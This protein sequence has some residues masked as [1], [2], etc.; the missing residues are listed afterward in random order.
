M[1]TYYFSSRP[2]KIPAVRQLIGWRV[3]VHNESIQGTL[4]RRMK[5]CCWAFGIL[6]LIA[7]MFDILYAVGLLP[8]LQRA[9]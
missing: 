4:W 1:K 9:Y 8:Q 2:S 6:L 7:I 3:G 5:G